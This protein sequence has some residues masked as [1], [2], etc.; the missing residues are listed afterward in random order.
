MNRLAVQLNN[1]AVDAFQ[2]GRLYD[3]LESI[4]LACHLA[5]QQSHVHTTIDPTQYRFHWRDCSRDAFKTPF[6]K[7]DSRSERFL[8]LSFLIIT[9]P[10]DDENNSVGLNMR[11]PCGFAWAIWYK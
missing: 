6:D 7:I 1:R 10:E 8:Y 11:C 3:A 9:A 4:S 2:D 5:A